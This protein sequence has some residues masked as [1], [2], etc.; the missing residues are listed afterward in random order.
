M[1]IILQ[2][3]T[4]P[5]SKSKNNIYMKYLI[6]ILLVTFVLCNQSL[7]AEEVKKPP[8]GSDANI[9]GD[10]KNAKTGEHMPYINI[11]V[12]NTVLGTSTD[13]TGHYFLKNLPTGKIV[14]KASALGYKTVEK[15]TEI[16]PNETLEINFIL[17]EESRL[18]ER[19]KPSVPNT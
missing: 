14:L 1:Q 10:V 12:K 5:I 18:S 15:E 8:K 17:E 19:P 11:S 9:I 6:N 4:I 13:A 2:T 16:N 3:E 7:W